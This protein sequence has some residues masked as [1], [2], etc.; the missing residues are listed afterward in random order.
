[1]AAPAL[2]VADLSVAYRG[3]GSFVRALRDVSLTIEP[4]RAL[5]IV[6]ESGSGKSTLAMAAMGLLPGGAAVD[7]GRILI[8]GED[9]HAMSPEARRQLRGARVS[10]VFQDPFTSLNPAIPVGRQ[11][12][13][14]LVFHAGLPP[15]AAAVRARALLEEVGI[16]DAA[17]VAAAYPHQLSGGMKQRAMIA[18]ALACDPMLLILDEPTTALDVTIEAQI[19]DLLE[20]LR[21][22]RGL[23][24]MFVSHN[25]GVIARAVDEVCVLYAGEV[26]ERGLVN[27]VLRAPSHPYTKGLLASVP[28]IGQ[29]RRLAPIPGRLPDLTAVPEGCIFAARCPWVRE[30]CREKAQQLRTVPGGLARCWRTETVRDEAWPIPPEAAG[31]GVTAGVEGRAPVVEAFGIT[32]EFGLG[33]RIGRRPW[34]PGAPWPFRLERHG[35][36]AVDAVSLSIGPG[37]TVGLVGESGCGKSTLGRCLIRLI[38]PSGGEIRIAGRDLLRRRGSARRDLARTAQMI[39]QNP[40]SS[41]NPRKTVGQILGRSLRLVGGGDLRARTRD[42]LDRVHLP[43]AFASR[44]P[45]ELSGG[46]KQRVGIARAVATGPRFI[47]CDEA[48]SALDVSVQA[49]V[50]NLLAELQAELGVA[51]LFISHDLSVVAH[52]AHRICV[53]YRGAIVESGP[54]DLVLRPP[55]HPYTEALLSAVPSI[56]G[57]VRGRIRLDG[58]V[59]AVTAA[60]RGCRFEDRCPRRVGEVCATRTPP[61][62]HPAGDHWFDCH[63]EARELAEREEIFATSDRSGRLAAEVGP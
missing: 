9:L 28:T 35:V 49:S 62:R 32:K 25:L 63:I 44:Y 58:G 4:G 36:R 45:H 30:R 10:I 46:E 15:P 51:Y 59:G 8:A 55:Y 2:E 61:R 3:R 40:D 27:D 38:E 54:T 18:T 34:H 29:Q 11:V 57:E 43:A 20:G 12:A 31:A 21:R 16:H 17:R 39:F 26:V 53:M 50:L 7:G 5:G 19:I 13:E 24:I 22:R 37:E 42:L 14:P 56:G 52:L 33:V 47:V 48:V 23:A 60:M 41:L 1:M 6:G